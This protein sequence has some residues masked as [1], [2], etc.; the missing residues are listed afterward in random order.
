MTSKMLTFYLPADQRLLVALGKV[1]LRHEHL[2]HILKMT[3]KSLAGLTVQEAIDATQYEGSKALRN[4]IRK[5]ARKRLGEGEALLKLQALLTQAGR[6]TDRRNDL[7]HG[8]WA[9][10][11]DGDPGV[12][13]APGE[14]QPLPSA[15]ELETLVEEIWALTQELNRARLEGFLKI[16]L[17]QKKE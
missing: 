8:L 7:T 12:M 6:L 9:Q 16:A 3:I 2:N 1:A 10:E 17:E 4:R 14:L 5:L 15:E 13:G 11:L